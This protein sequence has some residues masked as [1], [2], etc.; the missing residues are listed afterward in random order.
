MSIVWQFLDWFYNNNNI[1]VV[2]LIDLWSIR[3]LVCTHEKPYT[4]QNDRILLSEIIVHNISG[5]N[6]LKAQ[7]CSFVLA[8]F[9]GFRKWYVK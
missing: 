4:Y 8:I 9:V 6:L 1:V 7:P 5:S 2:L 3:D